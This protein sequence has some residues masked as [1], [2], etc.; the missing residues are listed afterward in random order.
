MADLNRLAR[1]VAERMSKALDRKIRDDYLDQ[2]FS[3]PDPTQFLRGV[4][5]SG[6]ITSNATT[7]AIT[8]EGLMDAMKLLPKDAVPIPDFKIVAV[9]GQQYALL[10]NRSAFSMPRY[11]P[12]L[13]MEAQ[14]D[15]RYA[16]DLGVAMP[17]MPVTICVDSYAHVYTPTPEPEPA[18]QPEPT[19]APPTIRA[20]RSVDL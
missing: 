1:E 19:P 10:E 12:K 14:P 3:P 18:A 7:T 8:V 20:Q 16:Q 13:D 9:G 17:R 2:H 5:V 15:F 6:T 4:T 11:E